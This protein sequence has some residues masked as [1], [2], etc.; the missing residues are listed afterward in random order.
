MRHETHFHDA[1]GRAATT[2]KLNA[3]HFTA[4]NM[5]IPTVACFQHYYKGKHPTNV[6][7]TNYI[8]PPHPV[9]IFYHI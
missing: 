9:S 4:Y 7:Y 5:Y 2:V 3:L 1:G 8:Y 6:T